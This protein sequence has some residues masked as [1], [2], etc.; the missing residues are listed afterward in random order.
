[1][2]SAESWYRTKGSSQSYKR[3]IDKVKL[4]ARRKAAA[5][6]SAERT[7]I[8]NESWRDNSTSDSGL[9]ICRAREVIKQFAQDGDIDVATAQRAFHVIHQIFDRH[10]VYA[11]IAPD[12]GGLVFYWRAGDMSLEIDIYEDISDGVWWCWRGAGTE[13]TGHHSYELPSRTQENLKSFLATF[14][15]E[16]EQVNPDWRD[17]QF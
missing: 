5:R 1:M 10:S 13:R 9:A 14:S 17:Q 8:W 3:A 2:T 15:K 11:T 12:N 16:V 4:D 6:R 7:E